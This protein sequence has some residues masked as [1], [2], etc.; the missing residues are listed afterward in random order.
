MLVSFL[1]ICAQM[2]VTSL[3]WKEK[4]QNTVKW[5]L[6]KGIFRNS[7]PVF[8]WASIGILIILSVL[9]IIFW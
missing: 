9:Y 4:P 2:V 3:I 5:S 7:D 6:P 8:I 1:I